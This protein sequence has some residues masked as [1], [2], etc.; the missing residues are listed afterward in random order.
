MKNDESL[1]RIWNHGDFLDAP[2]RVKKT[3]NM[4]LS[5]IHATIEEF[6]I[7][8]RL[9]STGKI[10]YRYN[11]EYEIDFNEFLVCFYYVKCAVAISDFG[12]Y[13]A[14]LTD[15]CDELLC[16]EKYFYVFSGYPEKDVLDIKTFFEDQGY[17]V[18]VSK[19]IQLSDMIMCI[20]NGEIEI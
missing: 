19:D 20:E 1:L 10:I 3:L 16:H 14:I 15:I 6:Q 18:I 13:E 7:V 9:K 17:F 8:V 5:R 11:F 2:T 4:A 12:K